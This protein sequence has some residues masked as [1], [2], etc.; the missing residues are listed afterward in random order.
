MCH[1]VSFWFIMGHGRS[2]G[3]SVGPGGLRLSNSAEH[4]RRMSAQYV[5]IEIWYF[6]K[7]M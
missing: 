5:P 3:G 2:A 6:T 7:L 1:D 4:M